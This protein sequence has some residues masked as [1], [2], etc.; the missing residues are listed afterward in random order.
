MAETS[1]SPVGLSAPK[2]DAA[3]LLALTVTCG[4]QFMVVIDDTVVNVALP[5]IRTDLG[6]GTAGLAWVVDAYLL[7][8]GGF[9]VLGGRCADVF[10]RRRVFVLGLALFSLASLASGL[11]RDSATIVVARGVQG[12]GAALLSPAALSILVASFEDQRERRRALG[13]WGGL[14][15]ISGTSGVL[16]G[17][18]IT[19][20]IGWRWVFFINVPIGALLGALALTRLPAMRDGGRRSGSLDGLG[21]GLVTAAV[22]LLVY[23]VIS[24]DHRAWGAPWTVGGLAASALLLVLFVL[25]QRSAPV[26]VIRLGMLAKREVGLADAITI[27]A[28]S[29]MF[30]VFFFVT[31]YMQTIHLWSPLR[32]GLSWAP[33][34]VTLAIFT[35]IC[36]RL[37]PV[38]GARV[39]VTLGLLVAS[40]GQLLLLRTEPSGSYAAE[41]LPALLLC[42]AGFGLAILPLLVGAVGAVDAVE[43][44]AASG[45]ISMA[46]QVGGAIGLA[47]LAT[48]AS[49]RLSRQ[50]ASG[51]DPL[52]AGVNAFHT[53]FGAAAALTAAA[54]L[55]A[56]L[57]PNTRGKVDLAALQ[58]V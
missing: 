4:A 8:F 27:F 3:A 43:S 1:S 7:L 31:L 38:L 48:V 56:L 46:Q 47:V 32:T 16:L 28:A 33:F 52:A 11:A 49:D 35:G 17:G 55:V 54:A 51:T 12:F 15:G 36:A 29:S 9:L 26:P 18:V 23:T 10:G 45:V 41:L 2:A 58:G 53:A 57:L 50:L 42:A 44:G 30:A 14:L 19:D 22:L 13:V 34:G 39:L 40:G 20:T 5:S 37:M 21:A 6:F 25:R 24:T